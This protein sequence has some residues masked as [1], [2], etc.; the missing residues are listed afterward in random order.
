MLLARARTS[1]L[2]AL[3]GAGAEIR[4]GSSYR[5]PAAEAWMGVTARH[6]RLFAA[7]LRSLERGGLVTIDGDRVTF[8]A[9]AE[10]SI[11]AAAVDPDGAVPAAFVP[12][13]HLLAH[14]VEHLPAV[15]RGAVPATD[16]LFPAS[17]LELVEQ[18]YRGNPAAERFNRIAAETVRL[19]AGAMLNESR[20]SAPLRILEIGAGTGGTSA[21]VLDGLRPVADRV[22][23]VYT[24]VSSRFVQYGKRLY[25]PVHPFTDFRTLDIERDVDAQGFQDHAC[26]IVLAA[27]VLHATRDIGRTLNEIK[28]L[29]KANG[30]L[31]VLEG[32]ALDDFMTFTFGL[33]DGWWHA[34]D[35]H[36]RIADSPLLNIGGWTRAMESA[37]F[38][39]VVAFDEEQG[40]TVFVAES[41]GLATVRREAMRSTEVM[42][43]EAEPV[44]IAPP[45]G[46]AAASVVDGSLRALVEE[47]ISEQ[48][49]AAFGL[50]RGDLDP[51]KRFSEYGA[52]SIVSVELVNL[53][54]ETLHL[55][56]KPPVLF[57]HSSIRELTSH[58][59]STFG[60]QIAADLGASH[61]A[62]PPAAPETTRRD[63]LEDVLMR[64]ESGAISLEEALKIA[65]DLSPAG[66]SALHGDA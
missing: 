60:S 51:D 56:L 10:R 41:N 11:I 33:L 21:A 2:A 42:T 24:D 64:L 39:H 38:R 55:R 48:V 59:V 4:P 49:I 43:S 40:Q 46:A 18:I 32:T 65:P 5:V 3:N 57:D 50:D 9:A 26:D 45:R 1:L 61:V 23:Y 22:R 66:G 63:V 12:H 15:L 14:C 29:L 8:T 52:D 53:L 25:E 13:A 34:E 16:V 47:R 30:L 36:L 44:A 6:R 17:S 19:A 27:N 28:R 58:I 20:A 35:E 7:L 62:P 31:I 54:N 37:G